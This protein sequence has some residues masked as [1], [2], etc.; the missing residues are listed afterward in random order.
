MWATIAQRANTTKF[1]QNLSSRHSPPARRA[2]AA[3]ALG[4]PLHDAVQAEH[5]EGEW[6]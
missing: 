2:S 3:E 6:D 1:R 4:Q 5:A